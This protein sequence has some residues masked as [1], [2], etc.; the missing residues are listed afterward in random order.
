MHPQSGL[1]AMKTEFY[2]SNDNA[3]DG[4][5]CKESR[6]NRKTVAISGRTA[7]GQI[8]MFIGIVHSIEYDSEREQGKQ[9]RVTLCD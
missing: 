2:I 3:N 1:C 7:E 8:K 9:W 5:R 6:H 4:R